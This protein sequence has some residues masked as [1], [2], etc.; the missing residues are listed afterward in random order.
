MNV[1]IVRHETSAVKYTFLV[2][3]TKSLK[4]GDLVKVNTKRG[5]ALAICLCDSFVVDTTDKEKT[6]TIFNAF[7]TDEPTAYVIGKFTY[8]EWK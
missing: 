1:V 3:E 2:P 6:K 4:A 7:G 5:N 8:D